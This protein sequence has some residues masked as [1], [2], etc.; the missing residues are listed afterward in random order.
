MGRISGLLTAT[1]IRAEASER[2]NGVAVKS[3]NFSV[4]SLCLLITISA[5]AANP[6]ALADLSL[7]EL[8]AIQITSVARHA[9]NLSDA[10]AAIF[11]ITHDDIRRSGATSIP[12][13]LRLA[14]NLQVARIDSYQYA[15]S[16]RGFNTTTTNK[17]QVLIDGRSVYTP[18]Y[19]GVFWDVQDVVIEDID[20]IEV[21]SGPGGTLWGSNAVNGVINIITRSSDA[22]QGGLLSLGAGSDERNAAARYGGQVTENTSYRVYAKGFSRDSTETGTHQNAHNDWGKRQAGFRVD[23]NN[24]GDSFVIQGDAYDGAVNQ[25]IVDDRE[26]SGHNLL[27]RWN[28][29][30]Q[31]GSSL[32]VQVFYDHTERKYPGIFSETLDTYDIDLQHQILVGGKHNIVWGGGYRSSRDD[33]DNGALLA[34][35]PEKTSLNW[36]NLFVQDEV[37][38]SERLR[39]TVGAKLERNPYTDWEFQPNARLALKLPNDALLWTAVSRAVRTPS[40]IDSDLFFPGTPPYT[41]VGSPDFQS[42]KLTAYEIG[43]RS[44]PT[45]N[46]SFSISTFYNDYDDLRT[47]E[48]PVGQPLVIDNKMESRA[49]GV[50]IWGT[51]RITNDWH[52]SAG[53]NHLSQHRRLDSDSTSTGGTQTEG[54][55]PRQQFSL[56]SAVNLPHNVEFDLILRSI[57]RLPDPD[58]AGYTVLDSRVGWNVSPSLQLSLNALNLFDRR[59]AEFGTAP[60]YSEFR[61]A[62]YAEMIWKF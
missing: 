20:R 2:Q 25:P 11:V 33:V 44:Q 34:F 55:D 43:Y 46:L 9:Q 36:T 17:L 54:N 27:A 35:L 26:F 1:P 3:G 56:R 16:A 53:Y 59:H 58:V 13:A 61:R 42:E 12:E 52:L 7:D 41:L 49:Y 24:S 51:Y 31:N 57:A 48:R 29:D 28:R 38:L 19:S 47:I 18:L 15:I 39:L 8:S 37:I 40:R 60:I 50:E 32:Q 23:S 30:L 21:I 4:A 6:P 22:T 14:P 45:K 5:E 62:L 10:P